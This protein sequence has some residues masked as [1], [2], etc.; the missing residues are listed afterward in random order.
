MPFFTILKGNIHSNTHTKNEPTYKYFANHFKCF[1][2]G[3]WMK[4][5]AARPRWC[6]N[7]GRIHSKQ[8]VA[9]SLKSCNYPHENDFSLYLSLSYV[10]IFITIGFKNSLFRRRTI[11]LV[12]KK[13][14]FNFASPCMGE[15]YPSGMFIVLNYLSRR[16]T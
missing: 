13:L 7:K 3:W 5:M 4:W 12:S 11:I 10:T 1:M 2:N 8:Q 16:N 9:N 6:I 15:L 14:L